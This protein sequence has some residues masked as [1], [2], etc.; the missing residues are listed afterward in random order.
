MFADPISLPL[1]V[2]SLSV[3][4]A[5]LT[6][7]VHLEKKNCVTST[8]THQHHQQQQQHGIIML[9][10]EEWEIMCL[11]DLSGPY[12]I[13]ESCYYGGVG[14]DQALR[15]CSGSDCWEKCQCVSQGVLAMNGSATM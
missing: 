13:Y 6:A 4:L 5:N 10:L 11:H 1:R 12:Q 2:I 15:G 7:T 3:A 8:P 9:S 14:G